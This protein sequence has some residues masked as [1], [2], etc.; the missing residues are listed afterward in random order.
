MLENRRR[1]NTQG[2]SA[3][4][5]L[6]W[7]PFRKARRDRHPLRPRSLP[8]RKPADI[9]SPIMAS[10]GWIS[11]PCG[12][13]AIVSNE[14][15]VRYNPETVWP[16]P[17]S[18]RSIYAHGVELRSKVRLLFLSGQ[19]GVAPDGSLAT[20]FEAQCAVAM[21]NVETLLAAA[22]LEQADM[23]KLVFYLTRAAALPPLG[24]LRRKRWASP[25]PPAV[26]TLVVAAL[27][28]RELLI[29]IDVTAASAS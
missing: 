5:A 13:A 29:E 8:N 14:P 24:E 25:T 9:V 27:A 10:V 12:R 19:I 6:R 20:H 4:R 18:F 11:F 21:T 3:T 2:A 26:T 22:A 17:E 16:V 23:V 7:R 1:R 15:V 28:R